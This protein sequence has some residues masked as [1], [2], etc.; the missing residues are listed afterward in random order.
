MR[1][2]SPLYELFRV[3]ERFQRSVNLA[4][5]YGNPRNLDDYIITSLGGAVLSRI[6]QGLKAH[7]K[8]RAWSITGPYGAGKSAAILFAAEVLGY[9]TNNQ[10]RELL[11]STNPGLL[12][13]L[14]ANLPGLREGGYVIVPLVGSREPISWTLLAG[15]IESLFIQD[16]SM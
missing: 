8:G 5:D 13:K 10:A 6:G 2:A 4:T 14:Y 1:E 15:L 9:P 3:G 16:I 7:S 11:R 12:E